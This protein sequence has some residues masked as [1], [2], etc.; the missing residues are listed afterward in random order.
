MRVRRCRPDRGKG[1]ALRLDALKGGFRLRA[2]AAFERAPGA[3]GGGEPCRN[4]RIFRVEGEHG[5]GDEIVAEAVSS[6]ELGRVAL[7]ECADQ[8]RAHG[9][10]W[11][12]KTRGGAVSPRTLSSVSAAGL[13]PGAKTTCRPPARPTHSACRNRQ[14]RAGARVHRAATMS[15]AR[16][17]GRSCCRLSRIADDARAMICRFARRRKQIE[18]DIPQGPPPGALRR[19]ANNRRRSAIRS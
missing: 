4:L 8:A 12:A 13:R 1:R 17:C 2:A 7:R 18:R 3:K 9:S 6:I 19:Q 16:P 10:D 15:R 11:R 14:E 5:L